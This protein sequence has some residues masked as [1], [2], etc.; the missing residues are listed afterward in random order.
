V[1][2]R[3]HVKNRDFE[4]EI[5]IFTVQKSLIIKSRSRSVMSQYNLII[6]KSYLKFSRKRFKFLRMERNENIS[7]KDF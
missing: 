3:L 5:Y 1:F 6:S 4:Y 2:G 7:K